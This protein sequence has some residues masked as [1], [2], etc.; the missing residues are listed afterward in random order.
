MPDLTIPSLVD[1]VFL[2]PSFYLSLFLAVIASLLP[3]MI[4]KYTQQVFY[5][6]DTDI[7]Q[8]YQVT[9]WKPNVPVNLAN[10]DFKPE[11]SDTLQVPRETH[12]RRTS[13]VISRTKGI[14]K[15]TV[16][17]VSNNRNVF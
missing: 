15:G 1:R 2:V 11:K 12:G 6:S 5:P 7:L 4:L 10:P 16:H 9:Y 3:R 13:S 14:P 8:E 17:G